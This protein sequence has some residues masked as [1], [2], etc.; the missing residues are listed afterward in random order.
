MTMKQLQAEVLQHMTKD[1]V[2]NFGNLSYKATWQAALDKCSEAIAIAADAAQD[3]AEAVCDVLYSDTSRTV[4][5]TIAM[6]ILMAIFTLGLISV[7]ITQ[8]LWQASKPL[9]HRASGRIHSEFWS[10]VGAWPDLLMGL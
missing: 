1:E 10:F 8:A 7:R 6:M 3:T 9:L 2:R 4:V 5:Q